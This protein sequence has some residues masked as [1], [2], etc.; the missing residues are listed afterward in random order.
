VRNILLLLLCSVLLS[1]CTAWQEALEEVHADGERYGWCTRPPCPY[2]GAG[3]YG[4]YHHARHPAHA[5]KRS[6]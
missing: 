1:G 6:R 3:A 2:Y 5:W 4:A